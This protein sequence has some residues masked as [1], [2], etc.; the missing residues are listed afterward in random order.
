MCQSRD[1]PLEQ[2]LGSGLNGVSWGGLDG[3]EGGEGS[4]P[5]KM[6]RSPRVLG[7]KKAPTRGTKKAPSPGEVGATSFPPVELGPALVRTV[8]ARI[9]ILLF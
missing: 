5:H 2:I 7:Y 8:A 4:S 6:R 9:A 1:Y 3:H